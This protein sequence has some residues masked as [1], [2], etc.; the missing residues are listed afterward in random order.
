VARTTPRREQHV[1]DLDRQARSDGQRPRPVGTH[2]FNPVAVMTLPKSCVPQ[3]DDATV[4]ASAA[5]AKTA[6]TGG[7]QRRSSFVVNRLL[8]PMLNGGACYSRNRNRTRHHEAMK[9]GCN[10]PISPLAFAT[11][12]ASTLCSR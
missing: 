3:T 1:V 4:D 10:H 11:S 5:L 6:K 2:F 8:C 9:L 7:G 12:S